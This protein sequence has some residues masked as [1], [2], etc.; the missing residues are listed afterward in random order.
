MISVATM[1]WG[2]RTKS[3]TCLT[4]LSTTTSRLKDSGGSKLMYV[5]LRV[6]VNS[7]ASYISCYVCVIV[8]IHTLC[9]NDTTVM[10]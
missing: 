10:S 6:D 5:V 1:D 7:V 4:L 9:R 3:S 8:I 2:I